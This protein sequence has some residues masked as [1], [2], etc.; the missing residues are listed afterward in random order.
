MPRR[1]TRALPVVILHGWEGSAPEH[2]QSW[3][4][5]ELRA[6]GRE[7]RYPDLPDPDE[8][9]LSAWRS[10]LRSVLADLSAG[11][12]DVVAHSL[13][14]VLWLHHAADPGTS[15]RPARVLLVAP[16]A[17]ATAIPAIA[18]FFPPPLDV[19]AVRAA[20]DGTVLAGG[21]DD[22]YIPEGIRAAYGVPLRLPT[23]VLPGGGHVNPD[24]GYGPWPAVLD[25][26]GRDNLAF[27]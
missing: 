26:C 20:A 2:W 13:G 23:T 5:D 3:L 21:T 1:P 27:Y 4:A 8:P 7:V 24:S 11:G 16:P 15:P 12:F 14:A 19:E 17:P 18:N 25:W 10:E 9:S 22:P 6:T